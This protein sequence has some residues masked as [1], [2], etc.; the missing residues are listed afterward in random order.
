MSV[1]DHVYWDSEGDCS[2]KRWN[3]CDGMEHHLGCIELF[4]NV[5]YSND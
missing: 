2:V 3:E 1:A 4:W 5:V